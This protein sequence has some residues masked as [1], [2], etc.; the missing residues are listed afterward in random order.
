M[1]GVKR[2]KFHLVDLAGSERQKKTG[3]SGQ[4]FTESKNINMG[5]L[6]L[7]N[8]ISALGNERR[9]TAHVPYREALITRLLQARTDEFFACRAGSAHSLGCCLACMLFG[10]LDTG[11]NP[12]ANRDH[13]C[14]LLAL[15]TYPQP[16]ACRMQTRT[17]STGADNHCSL[18]SILV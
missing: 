16:V 13:T 14:V 2:S 18:S 9:K 10:T 15:S 6:A 3:A 12:N 4:R 1:T 17:R 5:L 11:H 7:G 8:V